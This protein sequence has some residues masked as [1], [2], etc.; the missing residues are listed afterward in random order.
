MEKATVSLTVSLT[1]S[2][3]PWKGEHTETIIPPS[4]CDA[5]VETAHVSNV[6]NDN[7]I[8]VSGG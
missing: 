4:K 7:A 6:F 2:V 1:T 8:K 3:D 5:W